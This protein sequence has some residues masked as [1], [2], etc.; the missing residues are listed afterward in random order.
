MAVNACSHLCMYIRICVC[1]HGLI[2]FVCVLGMDAGP[3]PDLV[4]QMM[5]EALGQ[6]DLVP[7]GKDRSG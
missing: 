2:V 6:S 7:E 4:S 1:V 5:E 3:S